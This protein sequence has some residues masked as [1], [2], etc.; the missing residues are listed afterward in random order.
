[1]GTQPGT[2]SSSP[3]RVADLIGPLNDVEERYA[4][5][6]YLA[7]D[8]ALLEGTIRVSVVGS[9]KASESGVKR[10]ARLVKSLVHADV[11]VVSGL[12]IGID[13]AAHRHA[14]EFGG[15]TIAVLG[16]PLDR[17]YPPQNAALF[18]EIV[19]DHLAV[20]QF[21]PGQPV[22]RGNFPRRN[23]T[24]ALLSH[25]TVI[26]EA[27]ESSGSLS[28]GWEAIRLGRPLLVSRAL[29]DDPALKWPRAMLDHGALVLE[30]EADLLDVLPE[31]GYANR[32][33]P[34]F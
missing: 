7:G 9:R 28:Q 12:A 16:T 13:T 26:L 3:R 10:A 23:R 6:L 17:P 29:A 4:E 30:T 18:A 31:R 27:G 20:S 33:G 34:P 24:M 22:Q 25:A 32:G 1:M 14:I 15:R 19:R 5:A 21:G 2:D 8:P 11:V